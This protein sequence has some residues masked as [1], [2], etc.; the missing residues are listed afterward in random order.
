MQHSQWSVARCELW[1]TWVD[2]PYVTAC[3]CSCHGSSNVP[4]LLS[5]CNFTQ[6][7]RIPGF[8][9]LLGSALHLS[10][11]TLLCQGTLPGLPSSFWNLSGSFPY[12]TI[13]SFCMH[14]K[15]VS[16]EW[17]QLKW[18]RSRMEYMEEPP[19][20]RGEMSGFITS[21]STRE[22][23]PVLSEQ[24]FAFTFILFSAGKLFTVEQHQARLQ[25]QNSS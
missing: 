25:K 17:W 15:P 13:L 12:P 14:L 22:C 6:T 18:S 10:L 5:S 8:S 11:H 23:H 19:G 3:G 1:R 20:H 4:A 7:I 9:K 24:D 21:S 16:C 2:L